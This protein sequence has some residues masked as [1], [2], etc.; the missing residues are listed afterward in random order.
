MPFFYGKGYDYASMFGIIFAYGLLLM[1]LIVLFIY[2]VVSK[3][4]R[5]L[6]GRREKEK[7]KVKE[8]DGWALV[9]G[10]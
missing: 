5:W 8:D 1:F 9:G 4:G 2:L 7:E 6:E 3:V 10:K